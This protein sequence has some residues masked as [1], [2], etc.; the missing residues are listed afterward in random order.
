MKTETDKKI[1]VGLQ[2]NKQ[3][4][5]RRRTNCTRRTFSKTFKEKCHK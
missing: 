5:T 1:N 4:H 2:R 3:W